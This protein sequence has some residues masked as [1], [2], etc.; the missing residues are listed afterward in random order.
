MDPNDEAR[1]SSSHSAPASTD[2]GTAISTT[3]ETRQSVQ[4]SRLWMDKGDFWEKLEVNDQETSGGSCMWRFQHDIKVRPPEE[5]DCRKKVG[6]V[7]AASYP[8]VRTRW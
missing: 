5:W 8:D 2:F 4:S 1:D 7:P 6:L 3:R